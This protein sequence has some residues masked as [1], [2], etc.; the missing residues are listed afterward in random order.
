[1]IDSPVAAVNGLPGRP[2][3]TINLDYVKFLRDAGFTFIEALQVSQSTLLRRL[4]EAN[5]FWGNYT[6]ISLD[7]VVVEIKNRFPNYGQALISGQLRSRGIKVQRSRL[8]ESLV[9]N[10]PL[11][12]ARLHNRITRHTY[13][14]PNSNS[15]WHMD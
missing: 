13:L 2:R 11:R 12:R 14:V 8:R 1:M 15:L 4:T 10:N 3:L 6:D 5:I 9:R 7:Q